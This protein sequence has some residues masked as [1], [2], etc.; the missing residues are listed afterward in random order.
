MT[1]TT[2]QEKLKAIGCE[3]AGHIKDAIETYK[4]F[5]Q[6]APSKT[7]SRKIDTVKQRIKY[8]EVRQ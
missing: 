3:H 4:L 2:V 8:L 6:C 7:A 1:L 5:L